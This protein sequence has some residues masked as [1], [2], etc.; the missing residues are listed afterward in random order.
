[1]LFYILLAAA[2]GYLNFHADRVVPMARPLTEFPDSVQ[3][4]H[5]TSQSTFGEDILNVL[6]P[7]DYLARQYSGMVGDTIGLYIGYHD[8]GKESGEIHSPKHC[9]PG[10][11]WQELSSDRMELAT[12]RGHVNLVKA[13]YQKGESRQLFF[14]WFQVQNRTLSSEYALKGAE[15]VNSLLHGRRDAAFVRISVPVETDEKHAEITGVNFIREI[16][17]LIG[18]F[19]PS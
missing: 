13:V 8:G 14:Y 18:N 15:I 3:G 7:T 2:W 9:L 12:P 1:M 6:R 5:V 17:P 11:G 19:I 10:S 16:Y 4:W